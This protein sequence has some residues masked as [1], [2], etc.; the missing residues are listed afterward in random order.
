LVAALGSEDAV[1]TAIARTFDATMIVEPD[2]YTSSAEA[3]EILGVTR[4]KLGAMRR[5]GKVPSIGLTQTEYD[6]ARVAAGWAES[7]RGWGPGVFYP[8]SEL[9]RLAV[10]A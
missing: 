1:V 3:A 7:D 4:G 8:L 9:R 2:R 10:A 6:A 5:A